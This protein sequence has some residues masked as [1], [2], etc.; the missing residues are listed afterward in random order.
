M[1][2]LER[3]DLLQALT[4]YLEL[5]GE[6]TGSLVFLDGEAGSGK[7]TVAAELAE[8]VGR[9]ALVL[10]GYCDPLT[11]PRPLGPLRDVAADAESGFDDIVDIDDI[12]EVFSRVL[13]R[14][15]H[16]I[17]P[18]LMI[19]EDIHWADAATLDML[20]Y[21]GR[22]VGD[23]K[24]LIV[25][26]YRGDEIGPEHQLRPILGDLL[27]KPQVHRHTI[28][29]LSSV[30]V[31]S[32]AG[33]RPVDAEMIHQVTGGNAFYVTELLATE[34]SVPPTV[35]EA[36]LARVGK[37]DPA[38]RRAVEGVSI[39]PRSMEPAHISAL[40]GTPPEAAE[41]ALHA[42]VLIG[43]AGGYRF[44]HEIAR[45]AIVEAIPSPRRIGYHRRMLEI[46]A[47]SDDSARLAHHAIE[48]GDRH[49][50]LEHAPLAAREA[51]GRQ[52]LREA[53]R[54]FA[55]AYPHLSA[56]PP[57][58]RFE[59]L[60]TY[61]NC[62]YFIDDQASAERI[63]REMLE[64]ARELDDPLILGT[65]LRTHSRALWM[66]GDNKGSKVEAEHALEVLEPLG[67]TE[68][69]AISL[70]LCAHDEM[71]NRH[72]EAG[73]A[74]CRRAVVM[75]ERIGS[76]TE[77]AMA[78]LVMGTLEIVNNDTEKGIRLLE[79]SIQ[80]GRKAG[81]PRLENLAY[82]MLGTGGG[83][84]KVYSRALEWLDKGI[85]LGIAQDEDYAVAYNTA[86]KARIKCE[87]GKWDEAV[88]LA[89]EVATYDPSVAR[90][91]PVTALGALGRVRVRRGSPGAEK[92][93]RESVDLG[94]SG[95]L[96]HIWAPLCGLAEMYWLQNQPEKAIDVLEEPLQRV[97]TTDT[98]WGRGEISY[99]MWR[100]GGL[101]QVPD[102]LAPPF[103]MMITG[104]WE[105]AAAEW[106]RIG[107]PYEEA[108]ALSDGNLKAKFKALEIFDSLGAKPA[109]QWLRSVLREEGIDSIPRGPRQST[110]ENQAGLTARQAEVYDLIGHGLSNGDIAQRL[111]ISQK[112]VE[113]HVSAILTKLGVSTR[114]EAIA[115]TRELNS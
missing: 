68:E 53:V 74:Y 38:G 51:V 57:I 58:D 24:A 43:D 13:D 2:T 110:K 102:R 78:I 89:E 75:A 115:R 17:R 39:A 64:I 12:Y 63:A 81:A 44:R 99:W 21:L 96:Q 25:T 87:Q 56:L 37:L 54:F 91:S 69:L 50:I 15:Q 41:G 93:L 42:G 1:P 40:V 52:S 106:N 23:S 18:I 5:A 47:D 8:L 36:V 10:T 3:D 49:L 65:A 82:G 92:A 112:T 97:L 30:A 76:L 103:E 80:L 113:H 19:L 14:L 90:I 83:E 95:A 20:T 60:A 48:T 77:H 9:K 31:R 105:G 61:Q 98:T 101:D 26:T 100:V 84:V 71:L 32:L 73:M 4:G 28:E 111:F 79:E 94:A 33:E 16:S 66:A 55:A 104:E 59:L 88:T 67:D 29:M 62:L 85:A 11:T 22:R 70:R 109:G 46:L 7:T 114:G 107:C 35:Q 45:L 27:T 34:G 108:L 72:Y 6:G 86:W